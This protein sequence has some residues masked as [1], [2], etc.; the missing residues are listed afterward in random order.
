MSDTVAIRR[1]HVDHETIGRL[2][3]LGDLIVPFCVGV[4]AELRLADQLVDGP[5]PVEEIAA[6]V[7]VLAGPL[8][9][10][11]RALA[12]KSIF[13]EVSVRSFGLTPMAELLRA[14]HPLSLRKLF[15]V[16]DADVLAFAHLGDTLRTGEP[17]FET[18][19]GE[20]FWSYLARRPE[21]SAVFDGLM[22]TFTALE[23]QAV[24]PVYDWSSLGRVV[25]VGGGNGALLAGLLAEHPGLQG[26]L[27]DLPAVVAGAGEVLEASGVAGR[28]EVVEGSFYD[29]V[30]PGDAYLMKRI[31]YNYDDEVAVKILANVRA[32]IAP[33]G[34]LL[35]LE[36][37]WR[38]G[39][40]FDMGRL[41]DLK[42]LVLGRGRVRSRQ[43]LRELFDRAGFRL[44]RVIPTPMVAVVEGVPA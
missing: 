2:F 3:E 18:V 34:R 6:R 15:H 42:M 38:R 5:L 33:A 26:V 36:P 7:G 19:H 43:E 20:E 8:Y 11:M 14:D 40:A 29:E 10:V 1:E 28:C 4:A 16:V 30:P 17:A 27:Y 21:E 41:M 25:D 13:D 23:V 35:L 12:S 32:A 22:A 24:L 37:V 31:V 9:R 44:T 39:N